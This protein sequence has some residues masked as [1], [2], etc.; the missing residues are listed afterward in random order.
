MR[1]SRR[2]LQRGLSLLEVLVAFA[3][4]AIALGMLYKT[5]GS[6][7]RSIGDAGQYQRAV[8]VAESLL[9][10]RDAVAPEGWNE[11]GESAGMG[12]QVRTE[13]YP[14]AASRANP[15]MVPLHALY[16][17]VQWTER[18]L[19]RQVQLQTLRPQRTRPAGPPGG[20][21]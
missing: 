21:R 9:A 15:D 5:M 4:M 18:G 11:S 1:P 10:A 6:S 14:T 19:Q 16:M 20:A 2:R 13:P 12:W 17:T 8:L 3:I 7:A